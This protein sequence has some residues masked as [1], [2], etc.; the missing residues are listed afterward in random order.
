[1]T[2]SVSALGAASSSGT[3]L[4]TT[5]WKIVLSVLIVL[6]LL[7]V[8]AEPLRFFTRSSRGTSPATDPARVW[9]APYVEFAYLN[10]GYFFFA[11]EPG[12]SHLLECRLEYGDAKFGDVEVGRLRF[13]DKRAQR[14]RLLYHRHFMLAEFLHQLHVPPVQSTVVGDD[15][16]LLA[17]WQ[18][19]RARYE[20]IR[21]SMTRHLV[22]RYGADGAVIERVEHR[23]PSDVEVLTQRL[24]L[25]DPSLYVILPDTPVFLPPEGVAP[26][27]SAQEQ[28][29][30]VR[31]LVAPEVPAQAE[32]VS[33]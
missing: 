9:L 23:L 15:R 20:M 3:W 16:R 12:P 4:P 21:D 5:R 29:G 31:L 1:M 33:K 17:D 6:H 28:S 30:G 22:A 24:P 10:H 2:D 11:P 18:A 27:V 25:D 8:T 14:P 7:A 19:D 26:L 13:P 32:E